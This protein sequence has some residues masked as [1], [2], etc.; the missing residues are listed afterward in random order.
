MKKATLYTLIAALSAALYLPTSW[1][2]NAQEDSGEPQMS[3]EAMAEM[4]AWM[5][6][7]QPGE[8]HQ[9]L[10]SFAG[11]WHAQIKMWMGP[12]SPPTENTAETEA[13][14]IMGDRFLEWKHTGN[15]FG[16][17]FEGRAIDGYN[18]GDSRYETVWIDNFGT[19]II[20]YTGQCSDDGKSRTMTGE[21]SNPIE[22]GTIQNRVVYTWIDDDHFAYESF[23]KTGD[24]E[25]KNMEINYERQ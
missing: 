11:K 12:E 13:H 23:M 8:H 15:F 10:A 4:E 19:L 22:G 5:K 6:L 24:T 14:W 21:F 20:F 3:P 25:Y 1:A 17:P 16:M 18:N 7:A 2:Q 9:H